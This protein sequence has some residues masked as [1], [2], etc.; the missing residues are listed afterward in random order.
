PLLPPRGGGVPGAPAGADPDP[1]IL[2]EARDPRFGDAGQVTLNG[3]LSASVGHLGY[4]SS[5]VSSTNVSVEPAFDYFVSPNFSEGGSAFF[6]YTNATSSG[7]VDYEA[8]M[9]G[10]TGRIGGNLWL[11]ARVSFWPRLGVG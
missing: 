1:Q 11:G 10:A 4:D 3:A 7:G 8:T 6:R 5:D 2:S 9:V